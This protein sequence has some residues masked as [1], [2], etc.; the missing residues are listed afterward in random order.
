[1]SEKL[2]IAWVA[3]AKELPVEIR[4]QLE[5]LSS[6]TPEKSQTENPRSAAL[7][8]AEPADTNEV[9]R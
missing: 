3:H 2:L 4:Q 8:T 1:M 5:K 7:T 9:P 6:L